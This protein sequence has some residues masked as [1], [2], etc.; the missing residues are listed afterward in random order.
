MPKK[1]KGKSTF[2]YLF[3]QKVFFGNKK[4]EEIQ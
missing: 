4:E 2:F 3:L 1:I